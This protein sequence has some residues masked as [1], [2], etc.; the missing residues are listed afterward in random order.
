MLSEENNSLEDALPQKEQHAQ[1]LEQSIKKRLSSVDFNKYS[2]IKGSAQ[3]YDLISSLEMTCVTNEDEEDG[4]EQ[5][6]GQYDESTVE[7]CS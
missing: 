1:Q 2:W 6:E 7:Y 5:K 3:Q 4:D